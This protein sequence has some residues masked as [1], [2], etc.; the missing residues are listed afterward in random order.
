MGFWTM[1]ARNPAPCTA[2]VAAADMSSATSGTTQ[3][4]DDGDAAA[5]GVAV[6]AADG[7]AVAVGVAVPGELVWVAAGA[8]G[9]DA[10][11]HAARLP[12]RMP[13]ATTANA[14]EDLLMLYPLAG[15]PAMS[16]PTGYVPPTSNAA[17]NPAAKVPVL[18]TSRKSGPGYPIAQL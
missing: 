12:V 6:E 1:T 2:V 5:A 16:R 17:V 10:E 15:R 11:L 7:V 18:R 9:A 8:A 3:A 14:I 4:L 13:A